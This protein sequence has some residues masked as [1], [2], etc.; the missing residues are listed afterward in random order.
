MSAARRSHIESS[1]GKIYLRYTRYQ[2]DKADSVSS[3][4]Y[5]DLTPHV[6]HDAHHLHRGGHR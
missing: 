6:Q 5:I 3:S 1:L 4:P 2:C